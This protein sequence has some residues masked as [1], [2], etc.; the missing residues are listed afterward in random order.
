MQYQKDNAEALAKIID[1]LREK[2]Y[3]FKSLDDL[4]KRQSTV[5]MYAYGFLML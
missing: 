5:S 3:H 2:G 1:D 4:V